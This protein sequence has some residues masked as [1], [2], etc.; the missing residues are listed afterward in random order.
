MS[1]SKRLRRLTTD[2][3]A[4]TSF[5]KAA[6]CMLEHHGIEVSV[7]GIRGIALE[8]GEQAKAVL[9]KPSPPLA[10]KSSGEIILE[11]DGVMVPLVEYKE[12]QDRRK[13]KK[14]YWREIK[15]GAIQDPRWTQCKFACSLQGGD[16][17]G[18]QLSVQV[19]KLVGAAIPFTHGVGDGATWIPE[20]G[21]RISGSQYHHLIDL[22]HFC[23]YLNAGFEGHK[24]KDLMVER[25]KEEVK[26]GG[27]QKVLRRLRRWQKE[28]PNHDGAARCL[29][30][31]KNRPGQFEYA[32]ALKKNLP[33]G[34]GLIESTNRSLIQKR[35]KIAGAWWL[36]ENANKLA[37]L[38][39]LRANG[40]W[41]ELWEDAA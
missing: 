6:D 7:S 22:Y 28:N 10:E 21:E 24:Q 34:S 36:G 19:R 39:T 20:Q 12:S 37:Q 11:M 4:E 3:A 31:I 8:S 2:L 29:K 35:L 13:T 41:E 26:A 40:L 1:Y 23:E 18:D 32:E 16:Y 14:L 27:M 38:R 25:S 15:V 30:Y 5:R 9:E 33:I 17:L